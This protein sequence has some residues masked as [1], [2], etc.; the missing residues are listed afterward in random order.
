MKL[1]I[2]LIGM[3][4]VVEGLPYAAA[5]EAMR[6]WLKKLSEIPAAQ[7]RYVGFIAMAAGL[8]ICWIAQ[9]SSFFQ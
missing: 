7:L 9:R 5:P 6:E 2:L 8:L 1:L 3:V 4:L